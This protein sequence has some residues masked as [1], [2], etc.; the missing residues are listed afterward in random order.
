M[1]RIRNGLFLSC[2]GIFLGGAIVAS[3]FARFR[4]YPGEVGEVAMSY[5]DLAAVLLSA[6]GVLVAVLGVFMAVLAVWGYVH[7]REAACTAAVKHVREQLETGSA[8]RKSVDS[9]VIGH[10]ANELR[11][12]ELRKTLEERVD[13]LILKGAGQR[14][15]EELMESEVAET[16]YQDRPRGAS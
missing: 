15:R 8:L 6:V 2:F 11:S 7:F 1:K 4:V 5:G 14:A 13:L 16:E 10:V 3:M 12:G 9:A